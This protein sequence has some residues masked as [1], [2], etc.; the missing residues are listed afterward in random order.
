MSK[1]KVFVAIVLTL[2]LSVLLSFAVSAEPAESEGQ[3]IH[4]ADGTWSYMDSYG[5]LA[6]DALGYWI[7]G[8]C[9][10][11]D[12]NGIMYTGWVQP[13]KNELWYSN[14]YRERWYYYGADGKAPVE[15][16]DAELGYIFS[17]NGEM[18]CNSYSI[19]TYSSGVC[20]IYVSDETG[21]VTELIG[22]GWIWH[23]NKW[24]FV[25]VDQ[26]GNKQLYTHGI[27]NL[28]GT[29]YYFN[30]GFL[31]SNEVFNTGYWD[32]DLEQWVYC[33]FFVNAEGKVVRDGWYNIDG[34]WGYIDNGEHITHSIHNIDGKNYYFDYEGRMSQ[35]GYI[36]LDYSRIGYANE[37][38]ALLCNQ[39]RQVDGSWEY[40]DSNCERAESGIY[41]VGGTAYYF[42]YDGKMVT[43]R[44]ESNYWFDA[45]GAGR[46]IS[47]GWF[48]TTDGWMYFEDGYRLNDCVAEIG[49]VKYAF[50]YSGY[51]YD[52]DTYLDDWD[53]ETEDTVYYSVNADGTVN[54]TPGWDKVDGEWA[55]IG[56]DGLLK[57][58]WFHDGTAWWYL[59]PYMYKNV[60][61]FDDGRIYYFFSDG[62]Y[63]EVTENGFYRYQNGSLY[64]EN[65]VCADGW[66]QINGNWYYFNY[67]MCAGGIYD[68]HD[69]PYYFDQ[70]GVLQSGGW[71]NAGYTWLYADDSGALYTGPQT[72]DGV[73]Y[74]FNSRGELVNSGIHYY[75]DVKYLTN[76]SG[77][78][79]A[80]SADATGWYQDNGNWYYLDNGYFCNSDSRYEIGDQYYSFDGNGVMRTD[81]I[82]NGHYYQA[83]GAM[84]T[85]GWLLLNGDWYYADEN[86]WLASGLTRIGSD[87]YYFRNYKMV[88]G[89][90]IYDKE[91]VVTDASGRIS[92]TQK[93]TE[94]WNLINDD[95][96]GYY[97]YIQ[98]GEFYY[99]WLGNYYLDPYMY[100]GDY[101][102]VNN[103]YYYFYDDGTCATNSWIQYS[104][105]D[106]LYAK[107]DGSLCRNEWVL[108][109]GN[110]YY[111]DYI[112]MA[113]D[114]IYYI[115][116]ERHEFDENGVWLGKVQYNNNNGYKDGWQ[117]MDGGW[118][119]F[120]YGDFVRGVTKIDG[121]WYG[122]D[123]D[124]YL[125][126]NCFVSDY[127][128]GEGEYYVNESGIVQNYTGWKLINGRWCYFTTENKA[129]VGWFVVD[130]TT[131]FG[132]YF[133]N[134]VTD[135]YDVGIITG[136]MVIDWQLYNF[137]SGGACLGEVTTDGWHYDGSDW[138]YVQNG[139]LVTNDIITISGVHYAFDG[140]GRMICNYYYYDDNTYR[141]IYLDSNGAQVTSAGWI[142]MDDGEWAYVDAEGYLLTGT[143][144]IGGTSYFFDFENYYYYY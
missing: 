53:Y 112:W 90:Y 60:T 77:V 45:T 66:R 58:G 121:T 26:Y 109:G 128:D 118:K 96:H 20:N 47:D 123:Y 83:N 54:T 133:Y 89:T 56:E 100:C 44:I 61:L 97:Y 107:A 41:D 80:N 67:S 50:D 1:K 144:I 141:F 84:Y 127:Y 131:Y 19:T 129:A 79:I 95:G 113:K 68:I 18:R 39:W 29:E 14:E 69:V 21:R 4:N 23:N 98:N 85:N 37:S 136:Y 117:Y 73:T 27:Y 105:G 59:Y 74:L 132:T 75:D 38:G 142:L 124:G 87:L 140:N 42:D 22:E 17:Y 138:Y 51:L 31:E 52:Y 35:N 33:W 108:S 6:K 9:Y 119:Y 143:H 86:G 3:W 13:H 16:Y 72:I 92:Y 137:T 11:F 125:A 71:I 36:Y 63:V 88:V 91:I 24:Y 139:K 32:E 10:G 115:D 111:F 28:G 134:A 34:E 104:D 122:F 116:G 102:E 114:G 48:E 65:G 5:E 25:E 46:V 30:D 126:S 64:I 2:L 57:T 49:G 81:T 55:Y 40:Y 62:R 76:S 103:K 93:F 78:I 106:W 135:S 7:D 8:Y 130:G 70:D 43:E 110:W 120:Q 15:G 101:F 99:G 94:G 12:G 82:Y